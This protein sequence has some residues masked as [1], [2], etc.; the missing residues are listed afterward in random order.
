MKPFSQRDIESIGAAI[1]VALIVIC[2]A[3]I[4][5]LTVL[6]C[7]DDLFLKTISK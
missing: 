2:L 1:A 7:N 4:V 5:V 6:L 3:G